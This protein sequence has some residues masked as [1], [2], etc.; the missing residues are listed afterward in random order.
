MVKQAPR[1][2]VVGLGV[3]GVS[4]V[5]HLHHLGYEVVAFDTRANPP[6]RDQAQREF[7]GLELE[8]GPMKASRFAGLEFVAVSPGVP[9]ADPGLVDARKQ[10]VPLIGDIELFA[11]ATAKPVIAVTGANGKSTVTS[12]VGRMCAESGLR[13]VTAGNI[14]L[15]VLDALADDVTDVYVLELSSFQLET[16]HT[17]NARAAAVLNITPDHMDR[18]RSLE[19]YALAKAR[20]FEGDGLMVLNRDDPVVLEMARAGRHSVTFSLAAPA[21]ERDYGILE[22]RGESWLASG[23]R[24]FMRCR[25]IP[26]LGRH[27]WANVLAA[28][29]LAEAAGVPQDAAQRAVMGFRALAHRAERVAEADGVLWINDSKGTNVGATAAALGGMTRPVILIAGGDGKGADFT[30]LRDVVRGRVRR[31]LLIGRDAELIAHALK[32]LCPVERCATLEEAVARAHVLARS[33]EAVLMSPACAS[34]D[35]FR[36]FEHRGDVFRAAV[37]QLVGGGDR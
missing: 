25:D 12:L 21:T 7:P 11:R 4:C 29:A 20:I 33:G 36:N 28:L 30:L 8:I 18:Y 14:G 35:M 9:L 31:L 37:Q 26:L 16:T 32:D 34:F 5:R 27:N 2:G 24:L 23:G 22:H 10:G 3:T 1:A 6:G 17:L 15:P 19:E 13:T